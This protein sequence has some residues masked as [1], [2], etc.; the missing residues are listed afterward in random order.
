M[1][2]HQAD[3]PLDSAFNL[4]P[5][6]PPELRDEI[7]RAWDLPLGQRVVVSFRNG[8]LDAVA[9]VLELAAAPDY[10]WNP[11]QPL[12]LRVAGCDF[13]SRDI[14]RWRLI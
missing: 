10:P 14:E 11:R 12:R 7:A 6:A 13:S 9:G 3:L 1:P 5:A 2:E 4:A 8:Q